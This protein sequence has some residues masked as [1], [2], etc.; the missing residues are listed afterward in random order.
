MLIADSKYFSVFW[1]LPINCTSYYCKLKFNSHHLYVLFRICDFCFDICKLFSSCIFPQLNAVLSFSLKREV[2][3]WLNVFIK[4]KAI[5][6]H[7]EDTYD[8]VTGLHQKTHY[9]RPNWDQ[10]MP[11]IAKDHTGYVRIGMLST[12]WL[13]W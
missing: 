3:N 5:V 1:S 6:L 9:G 10:I 12:H 7:D 2:I 11:N 13:V 8:A 4:A